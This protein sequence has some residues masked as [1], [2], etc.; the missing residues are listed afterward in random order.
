MENA[1]GWRSTLQNEVWMP[2]SW[3][4]RM[5]MGAGRRAILTLVLKQGMRQVLRFE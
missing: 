4:S 5:A 3:A 1:I 2:A